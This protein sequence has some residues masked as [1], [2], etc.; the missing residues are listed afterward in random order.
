MKKLNLINNNYERLTVIKQANS[1]KGRSAW[2]CLCKCGNT[3]IV[4]TEHLRDLST[5]SCGCLNKEKRKHRA[6]NLYKKCQKY[7]PQEASARRIWKKQ[8]A[9][10]SFE[11]FYYLSQQN[12]YYC[13][14]KPSNKQNAASKKSSQ[15]MKDN[16]DFIY[17][18]LDRIDNSLS[19]SKDNCVSCCKY[20]NYAKR[21]RTLEEF[22]NWII[23]IY[24]NFII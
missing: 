8:Y 17:N 9:E 3:V 23:K 16:G 4:K 21:E 12:C 2:Q 14:N 22:K 15:S 24:N 19:H 13:G 1:I 7:S 18:G 6:K 5:K 10:M 11:D 20:C